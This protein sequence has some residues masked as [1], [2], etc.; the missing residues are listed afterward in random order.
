MFERMPRGLQRRETFENVVPIDVRDA[1]RHA[2]TGAKHLER[3]REPRGIKAAGVR[4]DLQPALR[5]RSH[6]RTQLLDEII[7]VSATRV[8]FIPSRKPRERNLREIVAHQ[9]VDRIAGHHLIERGIPIAEISREVRD[10]NGTFTHPVVDKLRGRC[11]PS[12]ELLPLAD[13][14]FEAKRL[15]E[16]LSNFRPES[17]LSRV[18]QLGTRGPMTSQ[19]AGTSVMK[20]R[21]TKSCFMPTPWFVRES[22]RGLGI[23]SSATPRR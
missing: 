8:R 9:H 5:D 12:R 18:N 22:R 13:A 21:M 19:L 3:T 23:P 17:E 2:R 16:L 4:D 7:G 14:P 20:T 1:Q 15:D 10:P 11:S 6:M